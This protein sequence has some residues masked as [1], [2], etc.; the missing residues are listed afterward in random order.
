MSIVFINRGGHTS[1]LDFACDRVIGMAAMC[2]LTIQI[3]FLYNF[4]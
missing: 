3:L 2:W 4:D 1:G